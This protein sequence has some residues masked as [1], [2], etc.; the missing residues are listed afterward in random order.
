[1]KI[2]INVK[3]GTSQKN[4]TGAWRTFKPKLNPDK[5]IGCGLCSQLCPDGAIVM[6]EINGKKRPKINYDY[7]KGCGLCA[8]ECPVKAYIM[9]L[10]NK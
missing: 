7:C 4:K 5:C 10:D 6:V 2:N 3:P 1:M 8:H 9:E